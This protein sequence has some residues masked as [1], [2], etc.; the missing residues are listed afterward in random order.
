M[1]DLVHVTLNTS[2]SAMSPCVNSS[3]GPN[4]EKSILYGQAKRVLPIKSL[5][6]AAEFYVPNGN[7][8]HIALTTNSHP[9]IRAWSDREL[10]NTKSGCESLGITSSILLS[11]ERVDLN[12]IYRPIPQTM[13]WVEIDID[14]DEFQAWYVAFS[15][16]PPQAIF[17]GQHKIS[18]ILSKHFEEPNRSKR[19]AQSHYYATERYRDIKI[20]LSCRNS[21]RNFVSLL[22]ITNR[23]LKLGII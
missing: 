12:G 23:L 11:G 1:E 9:D 3:S 6:Q 19:Q 16:F 5:A 14:S 13:A 8:D 7:H 21:M 22:L 15:K 18:E 17:E 2:P 10:V 4:N 20:L